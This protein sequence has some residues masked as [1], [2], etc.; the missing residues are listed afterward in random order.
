ML[1]ITHDDWLRRAL[2]Y[3]SEGTD[4]LLAGQTP[5]GELLSAPSAPELEAVSACLIDC[6][7]DIRVAR[8]QARGPEWLVR[9]AGDLQLYPGRLEHSQRRHQGPAVPAGDAEREG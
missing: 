8:L 4:L 7:D 5:L 3:Q 1:D 6:D 2:E 9:T